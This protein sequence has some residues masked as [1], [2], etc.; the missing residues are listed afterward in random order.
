MFLLYG[1]QS[2]DL[3][4]STAGFY[5]MRTFVVKG[6]RFSSKISYA[7]TQYKVFLRPGLRYISI[8]NK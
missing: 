2:V 7:L 3:R 1:N 6:S 4:K 5:M 8:I